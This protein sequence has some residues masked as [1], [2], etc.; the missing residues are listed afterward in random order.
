[1][2]E[3]LLFDISVPGEGLVGYPIYTSVPVGMYY[4][5]M[6]KI[7]TPI[8]KLNQK[9]NIFQSSVENYK[10][11]EDFVND[12]LTENRLNQG[13]QEVCNSVYN[14]KLT[15]EFLKW[16]SK[17]VLEESELEREKNNLTDKKT[18]NKI[19]NRKAKT[20]YFNKE[21]EITI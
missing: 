5:F 12:F 17:D 14:I 7:K 15:G 20:W 3:P 4:D 2:S 1:M 19:V 6:F 10:D 9:Q 13:F 21:N 11:Y 16:I 8:Y 18:I